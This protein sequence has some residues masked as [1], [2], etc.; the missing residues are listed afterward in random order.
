MISRDLSVKV[1]FK[2]T[3]KKGVS[4]AKIWGWNILGNK[5]K[6]L[7]WVRDGKKAKVRVNK[8]V[9]VRE[10]ERVERK[11]GARSGRGNGKKFGFNSTCDEKPLET[12]NQKSI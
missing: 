4:N 7:R 3:T 9:V 1:T 2:P 11:A 6:T 10:R 5:T 12:F 8:G